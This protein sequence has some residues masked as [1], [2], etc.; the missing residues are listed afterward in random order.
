MLKFIVNGKTIEVKDFI[1][2]HQDIQ[3]GIIIGIIPDCE[4]KDGFFYIT[5]H[6]KDFDTLFKETLVNNQNCNLV[7]DDIEYPV[8]TINFNSIENTDLQKFVATGF[9]VNIYL[10]QQHQELELVKSNDDMFVALF[11]DNI[12]GEGI[13]YPILCKSIDGEICY[14]DGNPLVQYKGDYIVKLWKLNNKTEYRQAIDCWQNIN[15]PPTVNK[16]IDVLLKDDSGNV[17]YGIYEP[18]FKEFRTGE[19]FSPE[20][21]QYII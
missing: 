21:W 18:E 12:D 2:I 4:L 17:V 14:E 16:V 20:F 11:H 13:I 6:S 10:N 19:L 8:N 7:I 5:G 3:K 15:F 9:V 1:S